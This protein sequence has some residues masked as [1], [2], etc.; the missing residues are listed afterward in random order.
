MND[1][2]GQLLR[3]AE[4]AEQMRRGSVDALHEILRRFESELMALCVR[5][6]RD[7]NEAEDVVSEVFFELW[8]R[9]DRFDPQRASL[10]SYLLL[11]T[12]SRAID[13]WRSLAD[14]RRTQLASSEPFDVRTLVQV[15]QTPPEHR[16]AQAEAAGLAAEKLHA[17]NPA[18]REVLEMAFYGGLT[19]NQIAEQLKLPLGTVKSHVRRGLARLRAALG[20]EN[21]GARQ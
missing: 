13:R 20:G 18:Q 10:R 16:V 19:H 2:D 5:I 7:A 21:A 14:A 11:L 8:T 15:D 4:L 9:R 12:R 3:D 1:G 6:L 17:L